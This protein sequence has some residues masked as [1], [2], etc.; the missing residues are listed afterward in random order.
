[1]RHSTSNVAMARIPER[2]NEYIS[3][4]LRR[5]ERGRDLCILNMVKSIR[6]PIK[7]VSRKKNIPP[8]ETDSATNASADEG[9]AA[10]RD[11]LISVVVLAAGADADAR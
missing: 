9:T 6:K 7:V 8:S 5:C 1:M 3:C 4:E 10:A 11:S 2:A